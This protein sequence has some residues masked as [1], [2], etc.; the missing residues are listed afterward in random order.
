ML[1]I[2]PFEF[3]ALYIA[4]KSCC[5]LKVSGK[6]Y[7]A[8]ILLYTI[9]ACSTSIAHFDGGYAIYYLIKLKADNNSL[10]I[11]LAII[12]ILEISCFFLN[13]LWRIILLW[14]MWQV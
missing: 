10:K 7:Q 2:I 8:V 9:T 3:Y 5:E 12:M 1:F 14:K 4:I 11:F 13:S 6:R